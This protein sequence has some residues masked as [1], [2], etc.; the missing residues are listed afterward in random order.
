[1]LDTNVVSDLMKQAIGRT[2]QRIALSDED[3]LCTSII[4]VAELRFGLARR[5]M[6]H[7]FGRLEA[8]L[9]GLSVLPWDAPADMSYASM[10]AA[11]EYGGLLIGANDMLIA[12]HA[13]A[14]DCTLVTDNEREF[15]RVAG[16]RVE[17]WLRAD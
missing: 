4:V 2:A 14:Q 3:E 9:A 7:L 12:A 13:L 8:V 16:L 10:R 1:M 17:N 15:R 11:L 5:N 6:P